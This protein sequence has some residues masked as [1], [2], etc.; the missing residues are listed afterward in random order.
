M[1]KYN[2]IPSVI[3]MR[4]SQEFSHLEVRKACEKIFTDSFVLFNWNTNAFHKEEQN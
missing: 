3:D 1:F 2:K 4:I